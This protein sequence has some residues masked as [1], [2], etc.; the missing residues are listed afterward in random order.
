MMKR[1]RAALCLLL[2]LVL[3]SSCAT[4][5]VL[6]APQETLPPVA[7]GPEAPYGDA[8]LQRQ[9]TVPL[10]LPSIDGQTLLAYY[11]TLTLSYD[12]HP[13]QAILTALLAHEGNSRVRSLG[14]TNR[15]TLTGNDP[16]VVSYGVCTVNLSTSALLLTSEEL[17]V[18]AQAITATLCE[19]DDV[20]YVNILVAGTPVAMDVTG[21]LP[22]GSMTAALGQELP[23]LWEQFS[24]RRTQVGDLAASTPLT[25]TATLYFPLADGSGV[26]A[27]PRRLSFSGQHPQQMITTL[28]SALSAGAS[29]LEDAIALPN[30]ADMLLF[31]PEVVELEGGGRRATLQFTTDVLDR[32]SKTGCDPLCFFASIT[33]TLT[34][35]VP[36]L[37]QVCI[38][39]GNGALT[40]V[41]S[42]I[43]GSMLFPGA[44]HTRDAYSALVMGLST[45]YLP[46]EKGLSARQIAL[47]YRQAHSPRALLMHLASDEAAALPVGLTD[48]DILGI[49]VTDDVILVNLSERYAATLRDSA[50]DQRM[51]AYSIV[52][53]LCEAMELRRVRFYFGGTS[54]DDL[55]GDVLWS[56]EFLYNP[57]LIT[58]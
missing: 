17:Y 51:M 20:S 38:L 27:E 15:L 18:A 34:S 10:Y 1:L 5:T 19:L 13:A 16:V 50:M 46:G 58:H 33:L 30:A 28:L 49:A 53:T 2:C 22:L 56:G 37:Q 48:A 6:T 4:E 52:T 11:D 40:S 55:G 7:P 12:Q 35:F 31:M 26:V 44:L 8:A 14:G 54:V 23:V 39:V 43:H 9:V 29:T 21:N 42:P 47:P 24:A 32:L 45:V 3:L 41:V 57:S 36:S 25:A